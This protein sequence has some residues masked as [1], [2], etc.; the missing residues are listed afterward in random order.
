MFVTWG[1]AAC[2]RTVTEAQKKSPKANTFRDLLVLELVGVKRLEHAAPG[3]TVRYLR[4]IRGN[5]VAF[6][7]NTVRRLPSIPMQF[8]TLT[9]PTSFSVPLNV[10][11]SL[12]K[13]KKR[14]LVLFVSPAIMWGG[15][16]LISAAL[17]H[18]LKT[19]CHCAH[20]ARQAK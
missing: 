6:E 19:M 8:C 5:M 17:L 7:L 9:V 3:V 13:A 12:L 4:V 11:S 14:F 1:A 10:F 15:R 16:T 18:L 20:R 2:D